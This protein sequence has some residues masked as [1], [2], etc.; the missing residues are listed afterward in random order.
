MPP[1]SVEQAITALQGDVG[2][3]TQHL[4]PFLKAQAQVTG[5]QEQVNGLLAARTA[6]TERPLVVGLAKTLAVV[7]RSGGIDDATRLALESELM[8][9][10]TSAGLKEFGREGDVFDPD[11]HAV[12]ASSGDGVAVVVVHA[13]GVECFG[14]VLVKAHVELGTA[15]ASA[16]APTEQGVMA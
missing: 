13:R 11:R 14:E 10:L 6:R 9:T 15:P 2:L 8:A 16:A 12:L 4:V 7:R 1:E 5:L 3:I